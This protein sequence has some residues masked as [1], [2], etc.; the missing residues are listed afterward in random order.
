MRVVLCTAPPD[1]AASLARSLIQD[2]LAA[3]VNLLAV[4]SVYRWE[5]SVQED[6]E[7]LL[8]IKVPAEGVIPLREALLQRHPYTLPEVVVLPVDTDSSHAA[9]VAWVRAMGG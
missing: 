9:Y 4:T 5:G 7:S 6:A 3:C 2:G 1:R 8:V